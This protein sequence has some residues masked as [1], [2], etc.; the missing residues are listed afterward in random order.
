MIEEKKHFQKSLIYPSLFILLIIIIKSFEEI[1]GIS[2]SRLGIYPKSFAGLWKIFTFPLIHKNFEHLISN[3]FPIL[4]LG[5]AIIY[6]Y[7]TAAP[8]VLIISYI[9]PGLFLWFFGRPAY[10]I[11]ASGMVY[12]FAT[13]L[14][15]SGLLRKDKRS[16]ALA[17]IVTFL[18]GSLVWGVLPFDPRISWEGHLLGAIVG[19]VIAFRYKHLDPYI[20]YDWELE[21]D[22]EDSDPLDYN[23]ESEER[24]DDKDKLF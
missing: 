6:F 1:S 24:P 9:F 3:S 15:F 8:R 21:D 5:T 20:K 13:F 4:I 12:A 23:P 11:G 7:K 17:L 22:D 19:I 2:L 10:H 14:F 18:Y 16:I